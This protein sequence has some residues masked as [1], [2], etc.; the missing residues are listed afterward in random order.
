MLIEFNFNKLA[1][2]RNNGSTIDD[3]VWVSNAYPQYRDT[4]VLLFGYN[5]ETYPH[6]QPENSPRSGT[7]MYKLDSDQDH[8]IDNRTGYYFCT[9]ELPIEQNLKNGNFTEAR[10]KCSSILT[11]KVCKDGPLI[12]KLTEIARKHANVENGYDMVTRFWTGSRRVGHSEFIDENGE[13][14][15]N[16]FCNTSKIHYAYGEFSIQEARLVFIRS[17]KRYNSDRKVKE[18][19]FRF[20]SQMIAELNET[21]LYWSNTLPCKWIGEYIY[22]KKLQNHSIR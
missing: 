4:L 22:I 2:I 21:V 9:D 1:W 15:S 12:E 3:F 16:P 18:E 8:N 19:W 20:P 7:F 5:G 11:P 17:N 13:I 10:S 6:F 14:T